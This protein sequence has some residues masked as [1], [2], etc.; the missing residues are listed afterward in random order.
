MQPLLQ[1]WNSQCR[2]FIYQCKSKKITIVFKT[3]SCDFGA[4]KFGILLTPALF[5]NLA[6]TTNYYLINAINSSEHGL[7][8]SRWTE[9]KSAEITK[10][11]L[12]AFFLIICLLLMHYAASLFSSYWKD[13][14]GFFVTLIKLEKCQWIADLY[15]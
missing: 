12:F 13:R 11:S 8:K 6:R 14:C 4:P 7:L 5:F 10:L 1:F 3:I 2:I 9:H 15:K